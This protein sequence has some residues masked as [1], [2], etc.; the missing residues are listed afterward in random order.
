MRYQPVHPISRE[1]YEAAIKSGDSEVMCDALVRLTFHEPDWRWVQDECLTLADHPDVAVRGLALTCLGHLARIHRTLDLDRV[2]PC[3]RR[4]LLD[5]EVAGR[6]ED[7]L[8][9]IDIF[10][11]HGHRHDRHPAAEGTD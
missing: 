9:D 10:L 2:L 3:L 7:A 1:E 4:R 6:A 8:D 5:P 11:P